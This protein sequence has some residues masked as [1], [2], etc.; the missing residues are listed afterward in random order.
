VTALEQLARG[1]WHRWG[2]YAKF[3]RCS[4]CG[5]Q[6]YCRAARYAGPWLCLDCHDLRG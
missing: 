4:V 5:E 2:N 6:R 3:T 1:A